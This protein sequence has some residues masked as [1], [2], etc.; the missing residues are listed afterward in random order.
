MVAEQ[1]SYTVALCHPHLQVS[2]GTSP[3]V[4]GPGLQEGADLAQRPGWVVDMTA[5]HGE[6]VTV[7]LGEILRLDHLSSWPANT[8]GAQ[9]GPRW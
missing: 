5:V 3:G 6:R 7:A 8:F 4:D 2:L 9:D 1:A